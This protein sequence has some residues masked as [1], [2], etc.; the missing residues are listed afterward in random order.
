MAKFQKWTYI[1]SI[2]F[3]IK[4]TYQSFLSQNIGL[5]DFRMFSREL[6]RCFAGSKSAQ[7]YA[8]GQTFKPG[9]EAKATNFHNQFG[10]A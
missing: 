7:P 10:P 6:G 5:Q 8:P 2:D 1:Q 9:A 4:Y 3:P